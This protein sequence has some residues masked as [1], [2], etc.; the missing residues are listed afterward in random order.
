MHTEHVALGA[1][2]AGEVRLKNTE[3]KREK[4]FLKDK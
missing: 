4:R 1:H 3:I 2:T